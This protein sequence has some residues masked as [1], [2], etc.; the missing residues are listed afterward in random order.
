ML[1]TAIEVAIPLRDAR[2]C[3]LQEIAQGPLV[4]GREAPEGLRGLAHA[5]ANPVAE[6]RSERGE[7]DVLDSAVVQVGPACDE[8][9]RFEP[10]DDPGNVGVVAVEGGCQFVHGYGGVWFHLQEGG[11]LRRVEIELRSGGEE[12]P[13]LA[14]HELME[15][16]PGLVGRRPSLSRASCRGHGHTVYLMWSMVDSIKV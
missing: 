14:H 4:G 1:R 10:V 9:A 5:R 15:E 11:G 7:N 8:A 16:G 12:A 6:L 2:E 3:A 13:A